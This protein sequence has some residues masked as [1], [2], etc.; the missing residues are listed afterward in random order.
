VLRQ[1]PRQARLQMG[2]FIVECAYLESDRYHN[3][4]A[5]TYAEHFAVN[6]VLHVL[7]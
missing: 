1:G 3:M 4:S 6:K 5:Y 2:S 7:I